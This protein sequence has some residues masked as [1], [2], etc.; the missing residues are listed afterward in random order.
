MDYCAY[1]ET[2]DVAWDLWEHCNGFAHGPEHV[3]EHYEMH[4][5]DDKIRYQFGMGPVGLPPRYHYLFS[6]L[7]QD[8]LA[9][10]ISNRIRWANLV[11]SARLL[12]WSVRAQESS[13]MAASRRCMMNWLTASR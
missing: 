11:N 13:K 2:F 9:T 1:Q 8:L 10:S 4:E 12:G 6:G 3:E 7:C 5:V